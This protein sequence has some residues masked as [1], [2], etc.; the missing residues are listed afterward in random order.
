MAN[1]KFQYAPGLPGYGTRGVDGSTGLTGLATYFSAYDGTTDSITIKSKIIA[2][3]ILFPT[4]EL[5]PGYPERIYLTGDQFIDKNGRVF[6]IDFTEVDL[7][8]ST[9][10]QLNTSGFFE[11]GPDTD[12]TPVYQRYSNA[13]TTSKFLIDI[14][15]ATNPPGNYAINPSPTET[16]YGVGATDFAQVK[17]VNRQIGDYHP[18]T[19]FTNTNNA[20]QPERAI[21]IT[22]REGFDEWHIGN[23]DI[24]DTVRDVSLYLDF[25]DVYV[26][27]TIHATIE[28]A[29][30]T[31]NLFLSGWL[32][33]DGDTSLNNTYV[34]NLLTAGTVTTGSNLTVNGGINST[35]GISA[36]AGSIQAVTGNITAGNTAKNSNTV[37]SVFSNDT[38]E[39]GFEAMGSSQ[40][41]GYL[42][43]GQGADYG[44]GVYYNGDGN[45]A[46]V[47]TTDAVSFYRR[48]AG[49][50]VQ[51]FHYM[52][53]SNTVNFAGSIVAADS[54]STTG[55]ANITASGTVSGSTVTGANVTSGSNPG[56]T[57]TA[58]ALT[59]VYSITQNDAR[60]CLEANNL[61][62]VNDAATSFN[63]IKQSATTS[64]AGVTEYATT[65]ETATG[66]S[67]SLSVYPYGFRYAWRY[68]TNLDRSDYIFRNRSTVPTTPSSTDY[69]A[70]AI[71]TVGGTG[72]ENNPYLIKRSYFKGSWINSFIYDDF[73]QALACPYLYFKLKDKNIFYTEII[74]NQKFI[75]NNKTEEYDIPSA[76][77]KDGVVE[78]TLTEEKDEISYLSNIKIINEDNTEIFSN[79]SIT[80]LELH[81]GDKQTLT[82][83]GI[84][85]NA[86]LSIKGYYVPLKFKLDE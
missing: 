39:A 77:I 80:K 25:K 68:A 48:T 78:L 72:F 9:G 30:T 71:S 22:K 76:F 63:N 67:T 79:E 3:K 64:Y 1:G 33:V 23:R 2:N 85:K 51:V 57:H 11:I 8:V 55:G 73:N 15:Y 62:D 69:S 52:H 17:Y 24:T 45:P 29:I 75:E 16:I 81:N 4:D 84:S 18:F 70:L 5:L 35:S 40:G 50:D 65:T 28:G 47:H 44:G 12:V 27:G 58:S 56:H 83:D 42:F 21:A 41:S 31:N 49:T 6:R 43:V 20:T 34:N 74:E 10:M 60:Y 13:Y 59:D 19:V 7:Y 53:N 54:I 14:V 38:H 26:P 86:K 32:R 36:A 66:S 37:I 82:F 46:T 61:S